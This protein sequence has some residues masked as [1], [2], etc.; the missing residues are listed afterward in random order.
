LK[1]FTTP[2]ESDTIAIVKKRAISGTSVQLAPCMQFRSECRG[3]HFHL[4]PVNCFEGGG[5]LEIQEHLDA[6]QEIEVVIDFAGRLF[7]EKSIEELERAEMG[8]RRIRRS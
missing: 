3:T 1:S 7:G 2:A 5:R 4:A 8:F 6:A